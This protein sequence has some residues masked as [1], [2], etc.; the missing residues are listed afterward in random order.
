MDDLITVIKEINLIADYL[1]SRDLENL[2]KEDLEKNFGTSKADLLILLGNSDVQSAKLAGQTLVD[3]VADQLLI[4]GR[5]GHSTSFLVENVQREASLSD[6]QTNDKS[7]AEILY[8]ILMKNFSIDL[9]KVFLETTST[10]CGSNARE[11]LHI[12]K[13]KDLKHS[14]VM[15]IQD[16]TMQLRTDASFQKEWA[17]EKTTFVNFASRKPQLVLENN[18]IKLNISDPPWSLDRFI[19]LVLGEIPRLRDDP[20]GYGPKGKGFIAHVD[21]PVEV[22]V[23]FEKIINTLPD[24]GFSNRRSSKNH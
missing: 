19:S 22:E 17:L 21:I 14:L 20:N 4:C 10:N 7:E 11:A 23:A 3:Q 5:R 13:E 1:A 18:Q 15:L 24:E 9:K 16:A 12:V 6:I 2:S 8:Q